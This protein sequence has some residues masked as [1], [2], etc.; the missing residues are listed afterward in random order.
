MNGSR[1]LVV[2]SGAQG[3]IVLDILRARGLH[4]DIEFVDDNRD[5][6]GTTIHGAR[7]SG[8]LEYVFEQDRER[9]EVIVAL[10]HPSRRMAVVARLM[11]RGVRFLNAIHP[12]AVIA[13]SADIGLGNTVSAGAI[14]NTDARLGD[15]VLINTGAIV[16]HDCVVS[17]GTSL[18]PGVILGGRVTIG[19]RAFLGLRALVQPRLKVGKD[20]VIAAGSVVTMD[21]PDQVLVAGV[22][23]RMLARV[24]ETFD[25]SRAM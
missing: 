19:R 20:A 24:D 25:W 3:R 4:H 18:S 2:G 16:E 23:A 14:V 5:V 21:V 22:P 10:G 17:D 8:G 1:A 6:W 11:A 12:A 7:V 15:H 9:C 13:P